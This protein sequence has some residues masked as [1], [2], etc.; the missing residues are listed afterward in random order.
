MDI[1]K[2]VE[3]IRNIDYSSMDTD[4]FLDDR[5]SQEFDTEWSKIFLAD[6][7]RGRIPNE[8]KKQAE[9]YKKEVFHVVDELTGGSELSEY[10]SED[11]ELLL[12]G[13]YLNIQSEWF[14]KFINKYENGELPTGIL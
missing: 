1:K 8:V 10:I 4:S 3:N 7:C 6:W 11:I 14:K 13:D 9:I 2:I 5:D 12:Y